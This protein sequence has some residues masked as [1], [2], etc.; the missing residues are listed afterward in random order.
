MA[1]MS[2]GKVL[3]LDDYEPIN[4]D[5]GFSTRY[6]IIPLIVAILVIAISAVS[7]YAIMSA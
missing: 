6:V 2:K 1:S 7:F 4:T 5:E 3:K